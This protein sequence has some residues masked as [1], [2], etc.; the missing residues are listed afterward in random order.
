MLE[1]GNLIE[2]SFMI[3]YL[4]ICFNL[5]IKYF[6]YFEKGELYNKKKLNG[7]LLSTPTHSMNIS[8]IKYRELGYQQLL[9]TKP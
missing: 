2:I 9:I 6:D 7:K 3:F 1:K 4:Y 5:F 8:L